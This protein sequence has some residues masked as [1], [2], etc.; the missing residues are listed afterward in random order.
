MAGDWGI[1]RTMSQ[2]HALLLISLEP[3]TADQVKEQLSISTG[4]A[5]MNLRALMD[6]G[7]VYKQLK[8]GE[9]KEFYA[10]EKDIWIVVRQ[11]I[12]HRKK[13]ELDPMLK[14]LEEVAGVENNSPE[15]EHFTVVVQDI[16]KFSHKANQTLEALS[17]ADS[18]W[19]TNIFLNM[20]R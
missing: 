8:S 10:A 1:N 15:A 12:Q 11:I 2:V 14:V 9:R 18:N 19:F 4:N 20:M 13:K 7:L 16:R 17:K 3:L 6:W 5:S